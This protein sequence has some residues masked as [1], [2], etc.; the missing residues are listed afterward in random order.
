MS[1]WALLIIPTLILLGAVFTD[2]RSRKIYNWYV[3]AAAVIAVAH[4]F[5]FFHW[6]GVTQ[7]LAGAGV[8]VLLTLPLVLVGVL[9]GGDMKLFVTFGLAT[10]YS[11]VFNVVIGSFVW[12]VIFGLIY[13]ALNGTLKRL[14][15]NMGALAKGEKAKKLQ[16]HHIPFTVAMLIGWMT[17][18]AQLKGIW[19]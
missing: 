17:Y 12:A 15:L 11:T 10:S 13:A 7:G 16:L 3:V 1:T 6:S 5:Y 8:A 9:G 4:S 2:L 19:S 14:F 18:V